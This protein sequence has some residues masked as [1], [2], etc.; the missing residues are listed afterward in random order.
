MQNLQG[1]FSPKNP[2]SRIPDQ[3]V[4]INLDGHDC[5]SNGTLSG[6][7]ILKI[8]NEEISIDYSRTLEL[9]ISTIQKQVSYDQGS[10][11]RQSNKLDIPVPKSYNDY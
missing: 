10:K 4:D 8:L 5:E 7:I 3:V 2:N 1:I 11:R 9:K 6:E